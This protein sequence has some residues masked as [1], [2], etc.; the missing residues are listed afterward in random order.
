[1]YHSAYSPEYLAAIAALLAD[2]AATATEIW[3]IFG[4]TAAFAATRNA[5]TAWSMARAS[6][7]Q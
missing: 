4:N 6:C 5:L 3:C 1:M 7:R 2:S